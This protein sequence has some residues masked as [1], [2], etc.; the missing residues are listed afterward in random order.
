MRLRQPVRRLGALAL[1]V[2]VCLGATG[3]KTSTGLTI[4]QPGLPP[5]QNTVHLHSEWAYTSTD[6]PG[7]E[8]ILL[9]YPLPGARA[10]DRQ[11]YIYLRLPEIDS[12]LV[13]IGDD[14]QD[15]SKAGGFLIQATGRLAG[16]TEFAKGR[17]ELEDV[18]LSRGLR[19]KGKVV[20]Y[21]SDGSVIRGEFLAMEAP[22][23]VSEFEADKAG[24]V[25]ALLP[26]KLRPK[27][28]DPLLSPTLDGPGS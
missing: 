9:M 28:E 12:G 5:P 8:R 18:A 10:G 25:N 19:R 3:C 15:G 4:T 16:K 2:G 13:R 14:I 7:L 20:L 1:L 11:F 22:L 6:Q 27:P 21:C 24:D 26:E 23:E 17:I